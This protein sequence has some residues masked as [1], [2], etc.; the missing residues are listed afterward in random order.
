MTNSEIAQHFNLLSDLMELHNENPFKIKSYS[1]AA[2]HLKNIEIPLQDLSI[3]QLEGIEG[4]GQAIA[5]KIFHLCKTGKFDLL[6][7]Y[8]QI[9]PHGIIE[10]LQLKGIGPKKIGQLWRELEIESLGE[11]EYACQEN[12]LIELKGFGAK[13]QQ[14]IFQQIQFIKQNAGKYLWSSAEEMAIDILHDLQQQYPDLQFSHCGDFRRKMQIVTTVDIL[15]GTEQPQ[16]IQTIK[17]KYHQHLATFH[18]CSKELFYLKL[19]E[20]SSAGAHYSFLS[21]K[22]DNSVVYDAEKSIYEAAGYPFIVPELRDNILEWKMV[23]DGTL[24]D[25]ITINDLKGIIHSHSKYS[26]GGNTL[27]ELAHYVKEQGFE[28]LVISDHSKSAFY[29]NGMK[30]ET[31]LEQHKEIDKLNIELAPFKIFKSVESDILID[32]QL[33][34]AD[35]I[36]AS[37]DL[38]IASV[39]SVLKMTEEKAMQRLITAIE[40]PYTTILGHLTGRLLLSRE[41][42]PVDHQKIIDAC[43]A[44]NVCIELNANPYRLDI[45]YRWIDYCQNKNVLVS[46]NPDAH[47]LHGVHDI[48]FG[49]NVARK[50]GLLKQNTLN[51]LTK[52]NFEKYLQQKCR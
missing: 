21:Y 23:E 10:L 52:N 17:E 5:A 39:H 34:Y 31:I 29:A 50:G 46:I 11:L 7:K 1:F 2:R 9:T 36:L 3:E 30:A 25:L 22:I 44:N 24:K 28:Y 20:L 45:D 41:G 35:D 19:L 18:F 14:N 42:Y 8:I 16:I 15:V 13:T 32:G 37:F 51:A 4:V 26:D 38:V 43:A 12:R 49:I 48:R 6:D 40:N 47:N 27:S 33:D